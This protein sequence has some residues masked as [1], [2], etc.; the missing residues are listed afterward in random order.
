[1]QSHKLS[2]KFFA[3][4]AGAVNALPADAFLHVFHSWIQRQAFPDHLLIDV[5][6]YHHVPDGPGTVLVSHE[7]NIHLDHT[8]GRTGLLYVRKQPYADADTARDRLRATFRAALAA[9]DLLEQEAAVEGR[10]RFSTGEMVLRVHDRLLAP[11]TPQTFDELKP[12]LEAV[13]SELY[14]GSDVAIE[15]RPSA[16]KLFEV[17]IKATRP[18]SLAELLNRVGAAPVA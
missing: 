14:S 11:N 12:D 3:N 4:D 13:L 17:R 18:P 15:H 10:V 2:L 6:D 9:C 7:A 16:E 1:M 8:D 5:A